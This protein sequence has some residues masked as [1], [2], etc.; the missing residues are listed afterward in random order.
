MFKR[1]HVNNTTSAGNP[2]GFRNGFPIN[3]S[4][5]CKYL[6]QGFAYLPTSEITSECW[7]IFQ[8]GKAR[9]DLTQLQEFLAEIDPDSRGVVVPSFVWSDKNDKPLLTLCLLVRKRISDF[10]ALLVD[11]IYLEQASIC[12]QHILTSVQEVSFHPIY[13]VIQEGEGVESLGAIFERRINELKNYW[14]PNVT[15]DVSQRVEQLPGSNSVYWIG[16]YPRSL[17]TDFD[18]SSGTHQI[19]RDEMSTS[20]SRDSAT[21][22]GVSSGVN[23]RSSLGSN[24]NSN[25]TGNLSDGSGTSGNNNKQSTKPKSHIEEITK[26]YP[27]ELYGARQNVIINYLPSNFTENDLRQLFLPDRKSVV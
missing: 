7:Q 25:S 21:M 13:S 14:G 17:L 3:I 18:D 19:H 24:S 5:L 27:V 10:P 22:S 9:T 23:S 4:F 11:M 12:P 15:F 1:Q 20:T 6:T 8:L 26:K 2:M 16:N